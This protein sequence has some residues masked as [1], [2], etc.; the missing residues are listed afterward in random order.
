MKYIKTYETMIELD[1]HHI[2][3]LLSHAI[4]D[5]D[6]VILNRLLN[7]DFDFHKNSKFFI[8]LFRKCATPENF[9]KFKDIL[10]RVIKK[11]NIN[12]SDGNTSFLDIVLKTEPINID[13]VNIL[14]QNGINVNNTFTIH[15]IQ[16]RS[17]SRSRYISQLTGP[18]ILH[19]CIDNNSIRDKYKKLDFYL[20]IIRILIK[21]GAD[22]TLKD[23]LG[24]DFLDYVNSKEIFD[25]NSELSMNRATKKLKQLIKEEKP[26]LYEEMEMREDIR[27]YNL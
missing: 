8:R 20:S 11:I 23:S 4:N 24:W 18:T 2:E 3:D 16:I 26:E 13:L 27:K 5:Y 14:I 9:N 1:D 7:S 15:G 19:F 25:Y 17:S 21:G 10:I 6:M 12:W 22:L